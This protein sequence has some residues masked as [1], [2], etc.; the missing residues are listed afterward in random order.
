MLIQGLLCFLNHITRLAHRTGNQPW[1]HAH[2]PSACACFTFCGRDKSCAKTAGKFSVLHPAG[3][4]PNQVRQKRRKINH[5]FR[6]TVVL[7]WHTLACVGLLLAWSYKQQ[8]NRNRRHSQRTCGVCLQGGFAYY[9]FCGWHGW[10]TLCTRISHPRFS[11]HIPPPRLGEI[12]MKRLF[13]EK[14]VIQLIFAKESII[15]ILLHAL[16]SMVAEQMLGFESF[17]TRGHRRSQH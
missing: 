4:T 2:P 3:I 9:T 14:F 17:V 8:R 7:Y 13:V 1:V 15:Q 16:E 5:L 12:D 11:L 10:G 6:N